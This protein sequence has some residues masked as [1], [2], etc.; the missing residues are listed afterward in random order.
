M[1]SE[2]IA[3]EP[4]SSSVVTTR[5]NF[6]SWNELADTPRG[7]TTEIQKKRLTQRLTGVFNPASADLAPRTLF[8]APILYVWAVFWFVVMAIAVGIAYKKLWSAEEKG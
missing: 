6:L 2:S 7:V 4:R 8:G 3:R 5:L 1:L